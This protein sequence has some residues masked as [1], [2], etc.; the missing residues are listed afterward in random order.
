IERA[1]VNLVSSA[2]CFLDSDRR[3]EARRQFERALEYSRTGKI[4]SWVSKQLES[5]QGIS[6]PGAIFT[7]AASNIA[8][9]PSL[10]RPQ[11][12]A[13][14]AAVDHFQRSREHAII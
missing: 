1:L 9:N 4:A 2:S 11:K 3:I 7:L 6:R 12:E 14:Q 10:R 8:Y 5:L 13:Y